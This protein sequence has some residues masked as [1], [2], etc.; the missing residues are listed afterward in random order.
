M[1]CE[2]RPVV[3]GYGSYVLLVWLK[4]PHHVFC[5]LSGILSI[6]E[7]SHEEHVRVPLHDGENG[8][9]V[10]FSDDRVHLKVPEA[11]SIGLLR[12][13]TDACTIGD[14][15]TLSAYGPAAVFEPVSTV[16]IEVAA[17]PLIFPYHLVDGLMG[18][19]L[20]LEFE[21]A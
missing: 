4:Q 12:P 13:F 18:Y 16:L 6:L 15:Y 1:A 2:L 5:E 7:L 14:D 8:A 17:L 11:L 20:S 10:P 19:V 9:M 21:M 3:S